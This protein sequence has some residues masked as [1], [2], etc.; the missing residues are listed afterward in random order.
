[1][2]QGYGPKKHYE[3]SE[4]DRTRHIL[5]L[6]EIDW[7]LFWADFTDLEGKHLFHRTGF[8]GRIFHV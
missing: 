5:P 4:I 8:K 1:M 3:I 7:G 2:C 6:S